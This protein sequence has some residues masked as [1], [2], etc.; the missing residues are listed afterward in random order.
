[1]VWLDTTPPTLAVTFDPTSMSGSV[2]TAPALTVNVSGYTEPGSVVY[3]N[4][5]L[6]LVAP[7]GHFHMICPLKASGETPIVVR[8]SDLAGNTRTVEQGISYVPVT[9]N[10]QEESDKGQTFLVVSIII[11]VLVGVIAFA[12][13]RMRGGKPEQA[14]AAGTALLVDV[15]AAEP[16]QPEPKTSKPEAQRPVAPKTSTTSPNAPRAPVRPVRP[17]ARRAVKATPRTAAAPAPRSGERT[18]SDQGAELDMVA[19]DIEQGGS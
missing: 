12:L 11:L 13:M 19:E 8:S 9:T 16:E 6:V 4:G 15:E 10:V 17:Q 2:M 5:V 14:E 1:V 3:V 7:D 18:L